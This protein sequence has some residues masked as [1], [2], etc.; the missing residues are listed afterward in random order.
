[1]KKFFTLMILFVP[2]LVLACP[3]CMGTYKNASSDHTIFV[4]GAFI[5]FTYFPLFYI[6]KTIFK[7]KDVNGR[8]AQ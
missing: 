6:F 4:L 5:L 8:K 7:Y 3:G 2:A 1:M